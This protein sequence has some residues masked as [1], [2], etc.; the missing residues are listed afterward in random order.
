MSLKKQFLKSKDVCKV[1]FALD[2]EQ[3]NGAKTVN[4]VGEFNNWD[5]SKDSLKK[6]KNGNFKI[7][8]D[9]ETGKEYEYK[10]LI[11]GEHW[12]NDSEA[13]KFVSNSFAGENSVVSTEK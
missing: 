6:F 5:E 8:M 3:V 12:L 9:L 2:S 13:D 11:D 1:T 10:Y 4:I 7:S